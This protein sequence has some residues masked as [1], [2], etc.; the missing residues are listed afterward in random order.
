MA[1]TKVTGKV[2]SAEVRP[3]G[4]VL[5]RRG[6]MLAYTG[7]VRFSPVGAG[8]GGGYGGGMAGALGRAMAGEAVAMMVAQGSGT[9]HYGYH[10]HHVTVVD[11]DGGSTLTVEADR[12]LA[13]DAHLSS[14]VVFLGQQ[15]GLRGAVRGAVTGQG[16]FT[17]Q[18]SGRGSVALLSHGGTFPLQVGGGHQIVVDPQ[19]FVASVGDLR[20][21]VAA[22]VSW[23]DAV[24]RGSGEAVQ[25]KVSGQGTVYVQAS[26]EKL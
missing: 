16:L 8:P 2:V 26:E 18:L 3:G 14:S 25:L 11:L 1:F 7:Q 6:A 20:V 24:G 9:V 15:G 23:R 10:G 17:T 21:D 19:A 13:H 12:L 22:N 5:A 4:E